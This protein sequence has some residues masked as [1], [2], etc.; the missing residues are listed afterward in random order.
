MSGVHNGSGWLDVRV[1]LQYAVANSSLILPPK[2]KQDRF[3]TRYALVAH[4]G[5]PSPS[6]SPDPLPSPSPSPDPL[7]SPFPSPDP[8]PSPS[9]SQD[10]LP[11]ID[12]TYPRPPHPATPRSRQHPCAHCCTSVR[13]FLCSFSA[14]SQIR[15]RSQ[16]RHRRQA[17]SSLGAPA[18]PD[19]LARAAPGGHASY[20]SATSLLASSTLSLLTTSSHSKSGEAASVEQARADWYACGLAQSLSTDPSGRVWMAGSERPDP[21]AICQSLLRPRYHSLE[22][23]REAIARVV[24]WRALCHSLSGRVFVPLSVAAESLLMLRRL[25]ARVRGG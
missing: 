3:C 11:S 4:C 7:P 25:R 9:P 15:T 20:G 16:I 22:A 1:P 10:P 23:G 2:S 13:A 17:P 24:D 14:A 19:R 8:L 6:P 18:T 21:A 5:R 12:S